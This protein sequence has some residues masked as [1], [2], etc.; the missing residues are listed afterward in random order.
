MPKEWKQFVAIQSRSSR[1]YVDLSE[2]ANE[3]EAEGWT[4]LNMQ[5]RWMGTA[6]VVYI[7]AWREIA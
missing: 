5:H 3:I 4:I 2:K 6:D 1:N 7:F